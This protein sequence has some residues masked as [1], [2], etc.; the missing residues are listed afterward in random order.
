MT[1]FAV[2]AGAVGERFVVQCKVEIG[3]VDEVDL[4]LSLHIGKS[5][6]GE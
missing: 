5:H 6:D 2:V 3:F 4:K 1:Y